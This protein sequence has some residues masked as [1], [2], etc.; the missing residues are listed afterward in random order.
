MASRKPSASALTDGLRAVFCAAMLLLAAAASAQQNGQTLNLRD[1]DIEAFIE[2]ISLLTGRG[3]IVDPRVQGKVTVISQT[4]LEPDAIFEVFLST[5]RVHGYTAIPTAGGVFRIVPI[6]GA[7][8]DSAVVNG[9][10]AAGDQFVTEVFRLFNADPVEAMNMIKPIIDPDGRAIAGR[11]NDVLIIVDYARNLPRIRQVIASLDRD[12][13]SLR[14]VPLNHVSARETAR[15]LDELIDDNRGENRNRL[16]VVAAQSSNALILRGAEAEIQT[17][18]PI[19]AELDRETRA[20]GDIRVYPLR[21]ALA[22]DLVPLLEQV[23]RSLADQGGR[24]EDDT[25]LA[26][27]RASIAVHRGTNSVVI[28]AGPA[29]QQALAGVIERLDIRRPQVLVEAIIV[30]VSDTAARQLGVQYV[31]GGT[32]GTIPFSATNFSGSAPN[33]LAATG[34]LLGDDEINGGSDDDGNSTFD[35][36]RSAALDSL[37]GLNGLT[38]GAGGVT[39]GG[40]LFGIILN[41]L[42]EDSGSNVLSTPS[43]LTMD[44]EPARILVGQEIPITTG[45][46]LSADNNN[47]FRTVDRQSVGVELEVRPQISEGDAI[48]L[49]IRQEVSAI[50]GPVSENIQELVTSQ[51]EIETTVVVDDGEIVVL[52]GLIQ[53][54]E[55]I[56]FEKI[57]LLGDIP[58]LGM[59]FRNEDRSNVRTNLMVFIR[60]TIARSRD[61]LRGVTDRRY[62]YIRREQ[63]LSG[64]G[65]VPSLDRLSDEVLSLPRS[66]PQPP[67]QP[68]GTP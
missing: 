49:A 22:E 20:Q 24:N 41:A 51:R 67:A 7:A 42:D 52:G 28:S 37:L 14:T 5:L 30:E 10:G 34:A 1:A 65:D 55:Q 62:D 29:M 27:P 56:S 15:L 25:P 54:D 64:G 12:N 18:L 50:V 33:I 9:R 13:S 3:F 59:L 17:L 61:D 8:P 11:D 31:L 6:D 40:T 38:L 4:P 39:D 43:L 60:P 46:V 48:K 57:P 68:G 36:L 58:G 45:E 53:D 63:L 47:P 32:E 66:Q 35:S 16:R 44:N 26:E 19:I 21:H 2:D 23:S